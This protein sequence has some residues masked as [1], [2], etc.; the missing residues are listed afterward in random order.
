MAKAEI[1][2]ALCLLYNLSHR[3]LK[4]D[5]RYRAADFGE[6]ADG[7]YDLVGQHAELRIILRLAAPLA[8]LGA[9]WEKVEDTIERVRER[10]DAIRRARDAANPAA[11]AN[12]VGSGN[13]R[14][15]AGAVGAGPFVAPK[16]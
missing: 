1:S 6:E 2:R 10:R 14:T 5:K 11:T 15:D 8:G 4:V 3:L 13:G 9:L 12:I 16:S 7:I